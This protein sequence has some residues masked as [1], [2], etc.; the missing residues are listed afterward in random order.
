LL[1]LLHGNDQHRKQYL[2]KHQFIRHIA[3]ETTSL[4]CAKVAS[5]SVREQYVQRAREHFNKDMAAVDFG[6][7]AA[8][9]TAACFW[10]CLAAGLS[11]SDWQVDAQALPGL[12]DIADLLNDVRTMSLHGLDRA[13]DKNFR[14]SSLGSL[15]ARLRFYMC[16]GPHAVLLRQDMVDELSPAFAGIEEGSAARQLHHYKHWVSRLASREYADELVVVAVALELNIRIICV[17]YTPV[18]APQAWAISTY[19]AGNAAESH[20]VVV[21]NNDVASSL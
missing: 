7:Y 3:R 18:A 19:A 4:D 15:A 9:T 17:P 8:D 11:T 13:C 5:N 20:S 10:L 14:K 12:S 21:G 16:G 6:Q 2:G 1:L